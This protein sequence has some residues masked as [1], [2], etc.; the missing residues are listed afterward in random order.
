MIA[1]YQEDAAAADAKYKDKR[2][3]ISGAITESGDTYAYAILDYFVRVELADPNLGTAEVIECAGRIEA[4]GLC[5]GLSEG[6][7]LVVDCI[8]REG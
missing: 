1:Q 7:V 2:I 5:R 6:L 8:I 4:R 3:V